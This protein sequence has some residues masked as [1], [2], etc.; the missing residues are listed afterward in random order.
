MGYRS[1]FGAE[2]DPGE[3]ANGAVTTPKLADDAVTKAKVADGALEG[4]G[5]PKL[6]AALD[7]NGKAITSPGNVDGRDV[8]A[9]GG[10]LDGH[11]ASTANPHSVSAAQA[12][13]L[14]NVIEDTTPQLGGDL[15]VNSQ[16]ITSAANGSI[17]IEPNGTG[18]LIGNNTDGT[19][20]AR[21]ANAVDWQL[22]RTAATEVASGAQST[23]G[24]GEKN[25]ANGAHSCVPGGY[26]N[27]ASGNYS[28]ASGQ[29][30]IASGHNA[31]AEGVQA[32]A[33]GAG[34]HA[35]GAYTASPGSYSHAQGRSAVARLWGEHAQGGGLIDSA[36]VQ[37]RVLVLRAQTTDAGAHEIL[38]DGTDR[39]A[40][41]EDTALGFTVSVVA[42][43][44]AG[45]D[46]YWV[47]EGV[48]ENDA[49]S[50][51]LGGATT[52]E[53]VDEGTDKAV[54]AAADDVNDSLKI[55]VQNTA[56]VKTNWGVRV[57]LV[58]IPVPAGGGGS[59]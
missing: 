18:A 58:E 22:Q 30:C 32:T 8:S 17:V 53:I 12:G 57:E 5:A 59:S 44:T 7:A 54:V 50:T 25:K 10:V 27:E 38:I 33:S 1:P 47:V 26:D 4:D 29:T 13:A 21:G 3:L 24:G 51:T 11:V 9:D 52:R 39:I 55:T 36:P 19:P 37:T 56:G 41:P 20:N 16:K 28:H 34:S 42:A 48:I 40:V 15:D 14:A 23:V 49:G 46:G 43:D 35:E 6:S 31:H 45:N 2:I